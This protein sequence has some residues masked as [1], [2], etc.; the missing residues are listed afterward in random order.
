[1]LAAVRKIY[2]IPINPTHGT[3]SERNKTQLADS[4]WLSTTGGAPRIFW[5]PFRHEIFRFIVLFFSN[6]ITTA[7]RNTH[8]QPMRRGDFLLFRLQLVVV[9]NFEKFLHAN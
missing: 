4:W 1:M 3:L 5:T 9:I 8:K 2:E 7:I 6:L